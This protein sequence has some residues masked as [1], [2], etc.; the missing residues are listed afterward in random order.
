MQIL[1]ITLAGANTTGYIVDL[2][3]GTGTNAAGPNNCGWVR[4]TV[5]GTGGDF[6]VS[7][8]FVVPGAALPS[9]PGDPRP[10]GGLQATYV[11]V[12]SGQ[13]FEFG[14]KNSKGYDPAVHGTKVAP[15]LLS[16]FNYVAVYCVASG[17]VTA[18]QL[19]VEAA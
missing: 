3:P 11:Q 19:R 18:T 2:Q 14:T 16:Y 4:I 1:P 8:G 6:W 10:T 5:N 17:T 15:G 12:T 9:A 7:V 13:S